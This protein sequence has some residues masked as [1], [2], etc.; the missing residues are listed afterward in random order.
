MQERNTYNITVYS[1]ADYR[2]DLTLTEDDGEIIDLTNLNLEAQL[3]EYP[4]DNDYLSFTVTEDNNVFSMTMPKEETEKISFTQGYYD[5]FVTN[6]TT[7]IRSLL[8]SGKA[9]IVNQVTRGE[10]L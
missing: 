4:E 3:R 7:E 5:I 1:G 10:T 8:I 9:I 6:S 2:L